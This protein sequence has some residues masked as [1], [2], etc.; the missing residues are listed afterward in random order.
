M[1]NETQ[2][3]RNYTVCIENTITGERYCENEFETREEA[4]EF[5]DTYPK[6]AHLKHEVRVIQD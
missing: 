1:K 4:V 6:A 3:T 2:P 5:M